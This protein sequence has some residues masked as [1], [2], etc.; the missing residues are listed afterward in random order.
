MRTAVIV[1]SA[2]IALFCATPALAGIHIFHQNG[3][4]P[5]ANH[6]PQP[7]P[8][9]SRHGPT[10]V[11]RCVTDAAVLRRCT[12]AYNRCSSHPQ[13]TNVCTVDFNRCCMPTAS[14][15]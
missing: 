1:L 3:G 2:A 6:V 11:G 12:A 4:Q 15:H 9:A 13:R 10:P 5:P 14:P 7:T 8:D